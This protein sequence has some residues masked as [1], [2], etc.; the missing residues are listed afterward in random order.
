[1]V[2]QSPNIVYVGGIRRSVDIRVRTVLSLFRIW[3]AR[4][5]VRRK[6]AALSERELRDMGT[7][8]SSIADEVGKPFWR[9]ISAPNAAPDQRSTYVRGN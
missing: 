3:R 1:M 2:Y 4:M 7:C 8:W 6:L 5:R 9:P